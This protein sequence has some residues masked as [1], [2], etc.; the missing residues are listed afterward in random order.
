M[1]LLPSLLLAL[2]VLL[3][4]RPAAAQTCTATGRGASSCDATGLGISISIGRA[5]S[6]TVSSTSTPLATPTPA[7]L[8]AGF[9]ATSGPS[10]TIRSNAPWSLAISAGASVWTASDTSTEP[11]RVDKP[12]GDLRWSTSSGGPF[13]ILQITPVTVVSGPGPTA[14]TTT[15]LFYR[16]VY[17]WPLDT[18]GAYSLQ[19]VFTL[20]AP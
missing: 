19:V 9:A 3:S 4:V 7:H 6:L 11:A 5:T 13:A 17:S 8:D 18:P 16:T 14:G 1:R 2:G 12:A 20:T 15:P 10:L